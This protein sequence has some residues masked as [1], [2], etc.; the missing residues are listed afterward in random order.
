[1]VSSTEQARVLAVFAAFLEHARSGGTA[2]TPAAVSLAEAEEGP[3]DVKIASPRQVP[4]TI[5]PMLVQGPAAVS[6]KLTPFGPSDD[7]FDPVPPVSDA[8]KTRI[9]PLPEALAR[10][11]APLPTHGSVWDDPTHERPDVARELAA[12]PEAQPDTDVALTLPESVSGRLRRVEERSI[13]VDDDTL[14]DPEFGQDAVQRVA[15]FVRD[16][17]AV[18][19]PMSVDQF[20]LEMAI[21]IKYGHGE[22]AAAE[23]ERWIAAH[24][25]D[26]SAHLKIAE[27]ELQRLDRDLAINRFIA[28]VSR[29]VERGDQREAQD[30][31]RRLRSRH[32]DDHR[33]GALASRV[34]VS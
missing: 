16:P 24:P 2:A 5:A 6:V 20:V 22:Q 15:Q 23:A 14:T 29:L 12:S 25:D 34:N 18:A 31:V 11:A 8:D 1:M 30:V 4:P 17:G 7:D 26:L 19:A 10:H 27:F 9:S 33:L 21:L 32:P 13:I 3:T 28:L